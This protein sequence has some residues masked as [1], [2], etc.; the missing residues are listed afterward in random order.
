[1]NAPPD[2]LEQRYGAPSR[3][4]RLVVLV[5]GALVVVGLLVWLVWAIAGSADPAVSS[6]E[7][8]KDETDAHHAWITYQVKYGDGPV[9]ATCSV[10]AVAK[11]GTTVGSLSFKPPRDAEP[12]HAYKVT[13]RTTSMA[14]SIAWLG[15]TAPGQVHPH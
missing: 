14:D 8:S 7:V 3:T 4:G 15:C 11:D 5:L 2:S 1:V 13:F 10:K 6:Q 12:D 9:D